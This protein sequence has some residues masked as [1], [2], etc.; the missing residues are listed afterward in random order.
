MSKLLTI[1]IAAYNMGAFI[2]R[3]LDSL[4]LSSVLDKLEILVIDDGSTDETAKIAY[5]YERRFPNSV[6]LISKSNA[7]YGSTVNT[8]IS[9]ATGKY[10]KVLDGDDQL[11]TRNLERYCRL[12]ES[13]NADIIFTEIVNYT[14]EGAATD[15]RQTCGLSPTRGTVNSNKL[16]YS[17][18]CLRLHL[19]TFNTTMLQ[20]SDITLPEHCL[21][22]D[23]LLVVEGFFLSQTAQICDLAIYAYSVGRDGQSMSSGTVR[24]HADDHI[25][26]A[27]SL[28]NYFYVPKRAFNCKSYIINDSLTYA[29]GH[30][31]DVLCSCGP[32]EANKEK[33]LQLNAL[34]EKV[35][36]EI[37]RTARFSTQSEWKL[38]RQSSFLLWKPLAFYKS[39]RH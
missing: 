30:V 36:P 29:V 35:C 28:I 4:V 9:E 20:N 39:R 2:R 26:I 17:H 19:C 3:T 22:T 11:I 23:Y 32:S 8:G 34:V 18:L 12:L 16:D 38:L 21:Y 15:S 27:Q 31:F 5:G 6:R 10:F 25:Y 1:S 7:G 24:K 14:V 13:S 37:T 33:A